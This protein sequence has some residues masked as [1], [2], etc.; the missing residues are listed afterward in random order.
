MGV[1]SVN[2]EKYIIFTLA[3]LEMGPLNEKGKREIFLMDN[4]L[5]YINKCMKQNTKL[6]SPQ[7]LLQRLSK[8][9]QF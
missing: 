2:T 9:L 1:N 8:T 7:R 5:E 4:I 3:Y 6:V